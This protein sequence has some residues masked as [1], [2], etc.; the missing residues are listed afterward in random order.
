MRIDLEY[1]AT[2]LN[3]FIASEAAHIT[4]YDIENSGVAIYGEN[5]KGLNEKFVFHAQ[6]LVEN[7]LVSDSA[8]R[9]DS[10]NT[11]GITLQKK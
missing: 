1:I 6:L 11:F 2:I 4:I 8:L 3:V 5:H 7:G 9:S 10:L